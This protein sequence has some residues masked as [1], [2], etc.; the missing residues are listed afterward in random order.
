MPVY[1]TKVI[2]CEGCQLNIHG[3]N[4]IRRWDMISADVLSGTNR[5]NLQTPIP[6][7]EKDLYIGTNLVIS[8]S[9]QYPA[10]NEERRIINVI[11][12]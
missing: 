8:T 3:N 2:A 4:K 1:G 6:D 12:G 11:N 5:I 7:N 9:S 10:D